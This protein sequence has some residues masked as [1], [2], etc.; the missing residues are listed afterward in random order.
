MGN[1][2]GRIICATKEEACAMDRDVVASFY[3]YSNWTVTAQE[4][5]GAGDE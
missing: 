3:P 2:S 1:D 4:L 5:K